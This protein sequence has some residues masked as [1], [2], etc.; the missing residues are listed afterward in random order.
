MR[1]CVFVCEGERVGLVGTFCSMCDVCVCVRVCVCGYLAHHGNSD[2]CR[3]HMLQADSEQECQLWIT[4]IQAGVSNAYRD[5]PHKDEVRAFRCVC[6]CVCV[7]C[8]HWM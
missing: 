7:C 5:S 1:A 2:C 8:A 3:S 4:A 6:V